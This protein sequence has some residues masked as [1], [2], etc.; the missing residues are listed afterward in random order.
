MG[1]RGGGK[2]WEGK[3]WLGSGPARRYEDT[4]ERGGGKEGKG[5]KGGKRKI[6]LGLLASSRWEGREGGREGERGGRLTWL[7][8]KRGGEG[9]MKGGRGR[10]G[11][12]A[13]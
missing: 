13:D 2:G 3:R 10:E 11:G 9:G 7:K 1:G 4:E 6:P 12:R 8:K 5:G